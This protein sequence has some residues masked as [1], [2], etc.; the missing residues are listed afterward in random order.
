MQAKLRNEHDLLAPIMKQM[1]L[2][3]PSNKLNQS[4]IRL[5][6]DIY[7]HRNDISKSEEYL[8]NHDVEAANLIVSQ[9]E[10]MQKERLDDVEVKGRTRER[11]S[12]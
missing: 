3:K 9:N 10:A 2:P 6:T 5:D 8:K 4:I 7:K 11:G 1:R 12:D